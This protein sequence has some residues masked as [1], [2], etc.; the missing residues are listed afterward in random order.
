ML[1][2]CCLGELASKPECAIHLSSRATAI[3][4]T[5][6]T[7]NTIWSYALR[8]ISRSGKIGRLVGSTEESWHL[9]DPEELRRNTGDPRSLDLEMACWNRHLEVLAVRL[10]AFGLSIYSIG[11]RLSVLNQQ[12]KSILPEL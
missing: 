9:H 2:H 10:V 1:C 5:A 8:L 11:V 12:H 6:I 4:Q 3:T 7:E